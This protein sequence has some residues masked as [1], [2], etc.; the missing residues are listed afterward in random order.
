MSYPDEDVYDG[1]LESYWSS[2]AALP[3]W[4]M[5]LPLTADQVSATVKV[6]SENQCPFGIRS[7]GHSQFHG[8]SSVNDG[9]TIDLGKTQHAHLSTLP[10]CP[11]LPFPSPNQVGWTCLVSCLTPSLILEVVEMKDT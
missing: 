1:R 2:S 7:G 3:P 10:L 6:L 8:S 11:S 9:V 5:V 4:C